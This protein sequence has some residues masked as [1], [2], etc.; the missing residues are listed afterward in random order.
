MAFN[1]VCCRDEATRDDWI[2]FFAL[3]G[4]ESLAAMASTSRICK[5]GW[6]SQCWGVFSCVGVPHTVCCSDIVAT[7]AMKPRAGAEAVPLACELSKACSE[8]GR[9]WEPRLVQLRPASRALVYSAVG[10]FAAVKVRS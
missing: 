2:A 7:D 10:D 9:L 4:A 6:R 1:C 8:G 3:A 5:F